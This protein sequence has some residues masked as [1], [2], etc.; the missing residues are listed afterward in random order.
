[1]IKS[2]YVLILIVLLG[3]LLRFYQLGSNPA[4]LNIDEVSI[5][6]NAYSILKTGKDEFNKPFPLAFRSYDDYKPP[7]YIYLTVPSVAVFGLTDFAV[8]LPAALMG[9]LAIVTTYLA[10]GELFRYQKKLALLAAF[11]L[12][13]LPWH[14]QFTRTAFE[15]G[16]MALFSTTGV[17]LFLRGVRTKNIIL[18]LMGGLALGKA[19]YL[20]QA[21]RLFLPLFVAILTLATFRMQKRWFLNAAAFLLAFTLLFTPVFLQSLT[22]EGQARFKG[23]SL[24]QDFEPHQVGVEREVVD[25]LNRDRFAAIGY[26]PEPLFYGSKFLTSY[27]MHFRFDFLFVGL[28]GIKVNLI[29]NVSLEYLFTLPLIV[30]GI[31]YLFAQKYKR[32]AVIILGWL[33]ISPIPAALTWE[34]PTSIRTAIM[35]PTLEIL[36]ALGAVQLWRKWKGFGVI[37]LIASVYSL[38][39]ML[40]MLFWHG[41]KYLDQQWYGTYREVVKKTMELAPNYQQVIVANTLDQPHGFFLYYS[42]YDPAK[43]QSE[44]GTVSGS[45]TETNNHLANIK[46]TPLEFEKNRGKGY[47]FVGRPNDF[48]PSQAAVATFNWA[49][50]T[51]AIKIVAE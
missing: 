45:Y 10:V 32:S 30:L 27:L 36:A 35:I 40:H 43:Y 1:M 41:P 9:T 6:Y 24:M 20:Y 26:H 22:P 23:T 5:G 48:P 14:L 18:S 21:A 4:S 8:R 29:P 25:W 15:V 44:G 3:F 28:G 38:A 16:A 46:F 12:A 19:A 13:I 51:P 2:I 31:Y 42:G 37:I 34:V 47:L 7:L 17:F 49:D 50:G 33:I 11:F 39:Y